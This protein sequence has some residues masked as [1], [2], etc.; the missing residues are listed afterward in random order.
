MT[1]NPEFKVK[2][3]FLYNP[4]ISIIIL[5]AVELPTPAHKSFTPKILHRNPWYN[6]SKYAGMFERF[7][8]PEPHPLAVPLGHP[9]F[10]PHLKIPKKGMKTTILKMLKP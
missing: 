7:G 1:Q 4:W 3:P 8:N 2:Y 9:S 10:N 5:L 6:K